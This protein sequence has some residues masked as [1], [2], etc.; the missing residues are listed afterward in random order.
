MA[1]E[2]RPQEFESTRANL[3]NS[4]CFRT[5]EGGFELLQSLD[6]QFVMQ[7][8]RE[9]WADFRNDAKQIARITAPRNR[10]R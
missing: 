7:P 2:P 6:L 8:A 9:L 1:R 5:M 3:L 4:A 10:S